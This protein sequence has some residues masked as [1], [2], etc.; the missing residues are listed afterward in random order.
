MVEVISLPVR[1]RFG[2]LFTSLLIS[3]VVVVLASAML[4]FVLREYR[5][6]YTILPQL[7]NDL[8]EQS[9]RIET[10]I[11]KDFERGSRNAVAESLLRAGSDQRAS[12]TIVPLDAEQFYSPKL[13]EFQMR[14]ELLEKLRR[15]EEVSEIFKPPQF[16]DYRGR[17]Y[18][19]AL[20]G[21]SSGR[22][23]LVALALRPVQFGS[24]WLP[25]FF[26]CLLLSV[27]PMSLFALVLSRYLLAPIEQ[28][29]DSAVRL[30]SGDLGVEAGS[31]GV[32]ELQELSE[33]FNTMARKLEAQMTRRTQLLR[34]ISHELATPITTL[35]ATSEAIADGI[36]SEKSFPQAMKTMVS[37]LEH[38]SHLVADITQLAEF[39]SNEAELRLEPFWSG[40]QIQEAVSASQ[41]LATQHFIE[42]ETQLQDGVVLADP[43][44]IMQVL[45]NLIVNAIV[46]NP[47]GTRVIISTRLCPD[48]VEFRV[49]DN[50]PLIAEEK[51]P[52]IF[53]RFTKFKAYREANNSGVGLGLAITKDILL[54]HRQQ[55][56]LEQQV[57]KGKVFVFQLPLAMSFSSADN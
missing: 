56:H 29:R 31:D 8:K 5:F 22:F 30:A 15:G 41:S 51:V 17:F 20:G 11:L 36:L 52:D 27:I 9:F 25:W 46:H 24:S 35:R 53:E 26:L 34:D 12:F 18:A 10:I 2:S 42:L 55:I 33:S 19:R 44:R 6:R 38:L 23:A 13:P 39:D 37:Q 50:G 48:Y 57:G 28:L 32:L 49:A 16:G 47:S 1:V 3:Y 40:D 43:L 54:R 21:N 14:P 7:V 45:K 4:A